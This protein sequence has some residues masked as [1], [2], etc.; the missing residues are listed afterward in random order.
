MR[1]QP[2][3][4][5]VI[6]AIIPIIV[7]TLLISMALVLVSCKDKECIPDQGKR[8]ELFFKCLEKVPKGPTTVE[9]NDWEEV[10]KQCDDSAYR[11]SLDCKMVEREFGVF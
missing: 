1:S 9:Y 5:K 2:F 8:A 11:I 6:N 4:I 10:V 3:F 7:M